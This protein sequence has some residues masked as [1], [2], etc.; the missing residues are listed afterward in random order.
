M[1]QLWSLGSIRCIAQNG[2]EY[3]LVEVAFSLRVAAAP[4]SEVGRSCEP[5]LGACSSSSLNSHLVHD[6]GFLLPP[7]GR[8]LP[9]LRPLLWGCDDWQRY[10]G[11][12]GVDIPVSTY[13]TLRL[14]RALGVLPRSTIVPQASSRPPLSTACATRRLGQYRG[15]VSVILWNSQAFFAVTPGRQELKCSY[16]NSLLHRAQVVMLTEAHGTEGAHRV[17]RPPLGT[18]AWWSAG[19]TTAHA[20]VGLIVK[21]SLLQKFD[22]NPAWK[23]I[24]PGRAAKLELRGPEGALDL[25][26][27]YFPTG[28]RPEGHDF[29]GFSAAEIERASSFHSLR[30]CLRSRLSRS[31]A[32]RSSALTILAGDFKYVADDFD[33]ISIHS[34]MSTGRRDSHEENISRLRSALPPASWRCTSQ[35]PP[36]LRRAPDLGW[37]G[38]T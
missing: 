36:M 35:S 4:S 14:R 27:A 31:L 13:Y 28:N 23:I 6:D 32:P 20:G 19:A 21:E 29:Y 33:R 38:C 1:A 7:L 34:A 24:L 8:L 15:D 9:P 30:G 11:T 17:W 37:T 12:P 25:V 10:L 26:V 2:S 22:P 18:A 3:W 5:S 16:V